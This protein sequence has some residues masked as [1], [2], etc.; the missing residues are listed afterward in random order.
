MEKVILGAIEKHLEDNTV[1]CHSQ[2]SFVRGKSCLSKVISF[3][4]KVTHWGCLTLSPGAV[5]GTII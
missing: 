2:H 1:T 5:L 4:D 3:Y